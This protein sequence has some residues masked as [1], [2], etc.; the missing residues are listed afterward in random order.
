M[1]EELTEEAL[2]QR[3]VGGQPEARSRIL[4][5]ADRYSR[6]TLQRHGVRH[7]DLDDLVQEAVMGV[8]RC[9]GSGRLV[10]VFQ[11]FVYFRSLS[12]LKSHRARQRLR[13][14]DAIDSLDPASERMGPG[15]EVE[16]HEL[17]QAVAHCR[18]ALPE[19]LR[20]VVHLRH[21]VDCKLPEIAERMQLSLGG[22][23]ERLRR[24]W[25][26]VHACLRKRGFAP[27]DDPL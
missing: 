22:V 24:A 20:M 15:T 26:L 13:Q 10:R 18:D 5:L 14:H 11:K 25:Q 4:E 16:V 8:D 19:S 7:P 23:R 27:E 6:A 9:R 2:W 21:A 12:I 1:Q 17:T 3:A